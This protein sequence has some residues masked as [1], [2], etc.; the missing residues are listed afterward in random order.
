MFH[1]ELVKMLVSKNRQNINWVKTM[2]ESR[3]QNAFPFPTMMP[4][5]RYDT[6]VCI[7]QIFPWVAIKNAEFWCLTLGSYYLPKK[8]DRYEPFID[9]WR[10]FLNLRQR[11]R[12]EWNV[13]PVSG[14]RR[15]R[16]LFFDLDGSIWKWR[17]TI[18][19]QIDINLFH[20]PQYFETKENITHL[21]CNRKRKLDS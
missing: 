18:K 19:K 15:R 10:H 13:R 8:N 3:A 5:L 7:K 20:H 6:S 14:L 9:A 16:W 4:C 21:T 12:N 1:R 2:Q 11:I 17:P